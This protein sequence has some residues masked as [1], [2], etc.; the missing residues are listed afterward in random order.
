MLFLIL[1]C[2]GSIVGRKVYISRP[3]LILM[4]KFVKLTKNQRL[5]LFT[6]LKEQINCSWEKFYPQWKISRPMLFNY[7][8][9][10][11]NLP[12]TLF[13][14]WKEIAK[15]SIIP[16]K[17]IDKEKFLKKQFVKP[18]LDEKLAEIIGVL[19]GDGH[20]SNF[21][22]EVCV[23]G[24]RLEKDYFNYLK[25][26]F[27]SK[28]NLKFRIFNVT[29]GLKM[30]CYSKSLSQFFIDIGLPKGNKLNKLK[31]PLFIKTNKTYLLHYIRGLF[32]TDGTIY[33]RR[34]KDMV[35]EISS[36][37]NRFLKEIRNSLSS[38]DLHS[39]LLKNHIAIYNKKDIIRFFCIIKPANTKHLKKYKGYLKLRAGGPENSD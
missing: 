22:Y 7:L 39:S 24:N 30:R 20:I 28:L 26:L 9:G 17:I 23:A 5:N 10:K 19:N 38:F 18:K 8:S 33:V 13:L 3:F 37:D 12:Y 36:A 31:I 27:Q 6:K 2:A 11:Y 21:K 35:L 16:I 14:E 29:S 4:V 15:I 32:D 34:K 25:K 1:L